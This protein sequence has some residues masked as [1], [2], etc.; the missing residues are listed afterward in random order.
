MDT[1]YTLDVHNKIVATGHDWDRF[2][3][4]NG[5]PPGLQ[6][7]D[8]S[9]WSI[10]TKREFELFYNAAYSSVRSSFESVT[11]QY[12]CDSPNVLRQMEMEISLDGDRDLLVFH[13]CL[14][15]E[16]LALEGSASAGV[17]RSLAL[18]GPCGRVRVRPDAPWVDI[19]SLRSYHGDVVINDRTWTVHGIC[20]GCLTIMRDE[21]EQLRS[22][23]LRLR[24]GASK[25]RA[26]S[27]LKDDIAG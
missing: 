4:E 14:A 13:R 3:A 19:R 1:S 9:L 20:D 7:V 10:V 26:I 11:I 12:R 27:F 18:C 17:I 2:A 22:E 15:E 24:Q 25:G 21:A 23:S 8:R 5:G 16:A 6:V